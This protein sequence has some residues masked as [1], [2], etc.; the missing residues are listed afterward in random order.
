MNPKQFNRL[1]QT[2]AGGSLFIGGFI[3]GGIMGGMLAFT[4]NPW[5]KAGLL[6]GMLLAAVGLWMMLYPL[7]RR[8]WKAD[9]TQT[10]WETGRAGEVSLDSSAEEKDS[11]QSK[12]K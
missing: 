6:A 11:K 5:W 7:L 4:E 9:Q 12:I 10:W 8:W 1:N 3:G 2:I